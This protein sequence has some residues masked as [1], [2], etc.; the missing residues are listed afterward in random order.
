MHIFNKHEHN[1][2]KLHVLT[3]KFSRNRKV[4]FN[5]WDRTLL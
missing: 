2:P 5:N 1:L 3:Y 4:N